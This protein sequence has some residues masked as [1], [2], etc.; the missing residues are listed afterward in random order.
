MQIKHK[1]VIELLMAYHHASAYNL[2]FPLAD[3]NL[4]TYL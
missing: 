4:A 1:H 2:L 3:M